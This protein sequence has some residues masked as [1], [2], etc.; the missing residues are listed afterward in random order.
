MVLSYK[1]GF[2]LAA[3]SFFDGTGCEMGPS[4]CPNFRLVCLI[5]ILAHYWEQEYLAGPRGVSVVPRSI[6]PS[7][8]TALDRWFAA[9]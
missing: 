9:V 3:R 8:H 7:D 5:A 6:V 2:K 4:L 1:T